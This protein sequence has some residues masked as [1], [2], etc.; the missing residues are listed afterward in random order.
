MHHFFHWHVDQNVPKQNMCMCNYPNLVKQNIY[1]MC[2]DNKI[3]NKH[4]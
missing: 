3:Y 4:K 2:F 1:E